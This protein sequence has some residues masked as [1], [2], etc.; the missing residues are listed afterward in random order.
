[1]D[2]KGKYYGLAYVNAYVLGDHYSHWE[3]LFLNSLRGVPSLFLLAEGFYMSG[4]IHNHNFFD[5]NKLS[6][7]VEEIGD[8]P[9]AILAD[10]IT[11]SLL[12]FLGVVHV[13]NTTSLSLKKAI[14]DLLQL[15]MGLPRPGET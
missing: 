15:I 9:Y 13:D 14:E 4:F 5:N 3:L 2:K 7:I 12:H 6:K 8:E 1:M 11:C 10:E